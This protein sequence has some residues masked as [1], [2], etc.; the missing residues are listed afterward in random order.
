MSR[1][2]YTLEYKQRAVELSH[3]PGKTVAGVAQELDIAENNLWRWREQFPVIAGQVTA[4]K[5][6]L[7]PEQRRIRELEKQL[8]EKEEEVVILKKTIGIFSD[9]K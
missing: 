5:T 7:T 9:R 4:R 8:A 2:Q 3:A 1:K 6:S